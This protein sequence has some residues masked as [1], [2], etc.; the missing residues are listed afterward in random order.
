[1]QQ[2]AILEQDQFANRSWTPLRF[3]DRLVEREKLR[4]LLEGT[5]RTSSF[6]NE[7]PWSFIIATKDDP[8]EFDRLFSCL[9]EANAEFVRKAPVLMLSVARLTNSFN[10]ERNTHAFRDARHA[11]SHLLQKAKVM[12]LTAEQMAG[13]NSAKARQ[14]FSIPAEYEPV[15]AIAVGYPAEPEGLS[16]TV[17]EEAT[18]EKRPLESFVFTGSWGQASRLS[19]QAALNDTDCAGNTLRFFQPEAASA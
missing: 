3:S 9:S 5:N 11:V 7:Q 12:G 19:D 4:C 18:R 14:E 10:G 1:M 13:F 16:L 15:A 17:I 2:R 8:I 6:M